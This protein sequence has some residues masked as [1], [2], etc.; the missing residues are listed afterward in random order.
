MVVVAEAVL[1]AGATEPSVI[2]IGGGAW[3]GE[4]RP[5]TAEVRNTA[6]SAQTRTHPFT[7]SKMVFSVPGAIS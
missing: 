6:Q 3:F 4:G 7:L 5:K 1:V 2:R